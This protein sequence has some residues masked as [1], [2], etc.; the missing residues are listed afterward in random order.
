MALRLAVVVS[1]PIQHFA[2]WHREVAKLSNVDL[3]VFFCCDWGSA[4]YFDPD[5]QS[6]FNWDV[7]LLEGYEYEFLPIAKRPAKLRFSEVDN[8]AVVDTLDRFDPNVVKVFGYAHKTNWRAAKWARHRQKPLLLCSDSNGASEAPAWKRLGKQIIVSHF[9]QK[10]DG[11]L[12]V[13]DNNRAYH[14]RFGLPAER[15][16][17]GS[18]PI[19]RNQL[20]WS[21]RDRALARLEIRR[22]HSIPGGAFVVM[23]CGKYSARKRPLDVIVAAQAAAKRGIPLWCL[24]VGEGLERKNLE[25]YCGEKGVTNVTLTGFV[26]QSTIGKY[27][28][29][30]DVLAVTS[31]FDPHPLVV[32][33]AAAFGLPVILSDKVGC[34]GPSDT[35][36]P[37]VNATVYP[38]GDR[39]RMA[40]AIE[41]LYR[42]KTLYQ[43][44]SIAAEKIARTQD[45]T[46]AAR[47]LAEATQ[48]LSALGPRQ[49]GGRA[50][51]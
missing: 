9:Y 2:P 7:P 4:S 23:F 48:R 35:A 41:E 13:G 49:L 24:L 14:Q 15:L 1:H 3:R 32:S 44:M 29:A 11:A 6:Q 16:F 40:E 42:N 5:F 21:V 27:Y 38:C 19:D 43:Q 39:A 33:E 34:I 8:P 28:A 37:G 45:V 12:C 51:N 31:A 17:A 26:N 10:V 30:S 25:K 50:R 36:R 22:R 47:E 18:L 20:L 46:V